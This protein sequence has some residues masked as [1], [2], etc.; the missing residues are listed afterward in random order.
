MYKFN[1]N[2]NDPGGPGLDVQGFGFFGR[3]IFLPS[4]NMIRRYEFADNFTLTRG[5][6]TPQMGFDELLRGDN[7]ASAT[8]FGGRFEFLQLPGG[9]V[10]P[11]LQ[12]PA[13]CGLSASTASAPISTLQ[14]W[15]LGLPSFY[16]QGFG[17][18]TIS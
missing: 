3:N 12:V 6:H 16:E 1:V 2:T 9:L 8:F 4:Y 10:S 15:S 14:S 7:S 11:C 17:E 5:R 18:Q 13:A